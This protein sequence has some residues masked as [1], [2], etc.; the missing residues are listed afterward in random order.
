MKFYFKCKNIKLTKIVDM[1]FFASSIG[2]GFVDIELF[3]SCFLDDA[4]WTTNEKNSQDP[5]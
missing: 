2:G 3:S 5:V 4:R 1:F